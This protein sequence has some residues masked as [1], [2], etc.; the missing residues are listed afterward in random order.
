MTSGTKAATAATALGTLASCSAQETSNA[1][2]G[3]VESLFVEIMQFML[4]MVAIAAVAI[5]LWSLLIA[6]GVAAIAAALKRRRGE[7]ETSGPASNDPVGTGML[8]F[9][10]VLVVSAAS[11]VCTVTAGPTGAG[12]TTVPLPIIALGIGLIVA[13]NRRRSTS[14]R[15]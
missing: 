9:G 6:G 15:D 11:S 13:A 12:E 10:I 2:E 7:G 3:A 8:V 4:I 5:V 1:V 14:E